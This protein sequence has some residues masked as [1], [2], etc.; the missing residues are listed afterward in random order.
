[1]R[2]ENRCLPLFVNQVLAAQGYAPDGSNYS[3]RYEVDGTLVW[4]TMQKYEDGE[5]E[6]LLRGDLRGNIMTGVID[7]KPSRGAREIYYFTTAK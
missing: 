2:R 1:M 6:A 4:E 3:V 7:I 5:G